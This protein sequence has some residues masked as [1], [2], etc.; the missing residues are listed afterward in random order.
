MAEGANTT[1]TNGQ[2]SDGGSAENSADLS[3]LVMGAPDETQSV[4]RIAEDIQA[5][6]AVTQQLLQQTALLAEVADRLIAAF[7]AGKKALLCGNGGSAADAQHIAAE[8]VGKF[9]FDRPALPAEALTVNTSSL[10]AIGNDYSFDQVFS[11]QV[12]AFGAAGDALIGIS[13]SGNSRNVVEAFRVAQRMG[14]TT[15]AFTGASG[16]QLKAEADYCICIASTDTPRIQEH[17][18]LVGHILCELV[19]RALFG[20]E[21]AATRA[22]RL[23]ATQP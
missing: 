15:I 21:V 14:I 19:E 4:A 10:T 13:T 9:Y 7:T 5:H 20:E 6:L 23:L 1:D 2:L 3:E 16:G 17:H 18:I 11:R 8:F 12:E 22:E